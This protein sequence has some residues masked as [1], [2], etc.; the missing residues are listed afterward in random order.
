LGCLTRSHRRI[1]GHARLPLRAALLLGATA[2]WTLV[3]AAQTS[4]PSGFQDS[5]VISGLEAP[6]TVRFSPDGRIF[7]GEKSGIV[8]VFDSL[9]DT[10]PAVF[11]DLRTNVHNFWDRGLLGLALDPGFPNSPYV[12]VLYTYDGPIGGA[13]PL[14]GTPGASDDPCPDPTG[15]GCVVSGR[16]S[17]LQAAGNQMTG[18][19]QVLVEGWFQQFP[20]HSVGSIVFAPDGALLA[21]GGEGASWDFADYGQ[22]G[23]PGGDPPV[24]AGVDQVAPNAEG[25][26]LRSQDLRTLSD[27][28]G[29]NGAIIRVNPA[30]GAAL[31]DNP[32]IA[33]ADPN[34]RRIV[35]YGFRNPFRFTLRPGTREIWVGDV[36]WQTWDE[37][38]R[39]PDPTAGVLNFG[40]PCYEGAGRQPG[41]DG[42]NLT[43]CEN[44]Y[45]EPNAVTAPF[46]QY[47]EGVPI[48]A[49][50][51]CGSADSAISGLAFYSGGAYPV[52]YD[53]ALFFAD[54]TR[55]CIWVMPRGANGDPDPARRQTFLPNAASPVD[56]QIGPGGDLFYA[57]I[58]GGAIHRIR[59]TAAPT[60]VAAAN[61]QSGIAPLTVQ[62]DGRA[63]TDPAGHPLEYDW[64]LDGDGLF[65]DSSLPNPTHTYTANGTFTAQLKVTNQSALSSVAGVAI[66]VGNRAPSAFIDAPAP[67]LRWSVGQPITFSGHATDPD[68]GV[69]P[70]AALK[71]TLIMH[72]CSTPS[73]CHEHVIQNYVGVS[74]A[75]FSAPDHEYPSY[76]ELRLTA[77][78]DGG[79]TSLASVRLDPQTVVQTFA[80]TPSGLNITVGSD[81][82]VT[83]ASRT[84]IVGSTA[85]VS[86]RSPQVLG[87][88]SYVF[89]SWSD[90]GAPSH[91]IV[92]GASP[93]TYTAVFTAAGGS[94]SDIVK[95]ASRAPVRKGTWRVVSD[96]SAAGGARMEHPDAGAPKVLTAQPSPHD[97]FELTFT[98]QANRPY[99]LWMRGRA[100]NNSYLNDSVYVQF[101]GSVD[102][103][104]SAVYRIGTTSAT[105]VVV[106]DC[107]GCGLSG[108]GWADNGYGSVG[109]PIYFGVS[110][111]QTIRIQGREDGV[112][113]DQIV[114]SPVTYLTA[115]PGATKND[116]VTLPESTDA[117]ASSTIVRYAADAAPPHGTWRLVPDATAAGG[118][119]MEHPDAGAPK[120][121]TP[122]AAP[123]DFFDVTLTAEAGRPYR[124]WLRGRAKSDSYLNDS[125]FVQFSGSVNAGGAAVY[126]IGSSDATTVV[127][128]ACSGCGLSGWG[129]A[130][131]GYG[132]LGPL[133]YFS[134]SGTQTLRIQGREDGVSVDQIVLSPD[135]YV[136]ASPGAA[137]NDSVILVRTP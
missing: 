3:V 21:S 20:S 91:N 79:L 25:G 6:T 124:L 76:L 68:T 74:G 120:L 135:T 4:P 75:T 103:A 5:I 38:N 134:T 104:G 111:A 34:A 62:F 61:P 95:Y 100:Q 18:P 14:W 29:L 10:S 127:I 77:T 132:T 46:F 8:K 31:P 131:N 35:A 32:L 102:A 115:A 130:D 69:L 1:H 15:K 22:V 82:L 16:L 125:V 107:S 90:G 133:I 96:A 105:T 43:L 85:S 78:D 112:S 33:A 93:A 63:S 55:N 108:W 59:Y 94:S 41:Y 49:G 2:I 99:R 122:L 83:P 106:E 136:T 44:L 118:A 13:A 23:N 57:D 28:V 12:Y 123:I 128:E 26:A 66:T 97:Y 84:V 50:E 86:A 9:T 129:W 71:W 116:T 47:R 88:T 11:A 30:T 48:V 52:Q 65:G 24:A 40:W 39:I 7:V 37:I 36:G 45:A 60:A 80:S 67:T 117:P 70:A 58:T 19:E 53:G 42:A 27:P 51:A 54:Y 101:S 114:L 89:T 17:R 72:H 56:L 119:R 110:G 73:T 126:R 92:A 113:L 64:D 87:S 98:A 121:V 81:S 109:P 137:K